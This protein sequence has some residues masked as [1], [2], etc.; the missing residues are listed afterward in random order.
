MSGFGVKTPLRRVIVTRDYFFNTAK[1]LL[2]FLQDYFEDDSYTYYTIIKE[3]SLN[4]ARKIARDEL[5][6]KSCL[7]ARMLSI[8]NN[9]TTQ[10]KSFSK[11][12]PPMVGRIQGLL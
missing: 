8:F 2:V 10:I 3:S 7:K 9:G 5:P 11:F 12:S 6:I 4:N 1:E